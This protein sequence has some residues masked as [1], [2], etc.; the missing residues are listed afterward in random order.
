MDVFTLSPEKSRQRRS[1]M[2]R[3]LRLRSFAKTEVDAKVVLRDIAAG[4][5]DFIHLL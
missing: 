1:A 2:D 4:A 3:D 5:S